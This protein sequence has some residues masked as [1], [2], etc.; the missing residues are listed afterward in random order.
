[1]GLFPAAID[2]VPWRAHRNN[3]LANEDIARS[4]QISLSEFAMVAIGL[5]HGYYNFGC[6]CAVFPWLRA[7]FL[8]QSKNSVSEAL[9]PLP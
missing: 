7:F 6:H 2:C 4:E 3:S 5:V 1:L 8:I 9:L